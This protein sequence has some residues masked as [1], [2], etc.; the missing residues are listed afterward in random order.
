MEC[1][2][3]ELLQLF[4]LKICKF[5]NFAVPL[6]SIPTFEGVYPARSVSKGSFLGRFLTYLNSVYC[7]LCLTHET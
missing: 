7:A 4:L 6:R 5:T 3:L 2:L 1:K